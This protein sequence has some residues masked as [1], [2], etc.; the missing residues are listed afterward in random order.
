MVGLTCRIVRECEECVE[1]DVFAY[2]IRAL[3]GMLVSKT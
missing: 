1:G 3:T 2:C